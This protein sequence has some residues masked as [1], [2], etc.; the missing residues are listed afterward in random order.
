MP[1]VHQQRRD[2]IAGVALVV[3]SAVSYGTV[4]ILAK[5]T[6]R[7]GVTLPEFL[8][9]RFGVAAVLLWIVVAATRGALPRRDRVLALVL[10][11]A[12][13]YAGQSAAFFAALE[14]IPASTT[15]LLL[16]IYPAVV[17]LAAAALLHE[18]LTARK[19]WAIVIAFAGTSMLV[20]GQLSGAEPVGIA[21]ALL[22][23]VI[24]SAYVLAGSRLFADLPPLATAATVM[25]STAA[26][27]I[28]FALLAGRFA[29]PAGASQLGLIGAV[30]IV[31]TAIPVLAFVVG[32]PRIG[33]SRASI[34]STF[35]P[36]VTVLLATVVLAEP[37]RPLQLAGAA[38]IVASVVVLEAGRP[39]GQPA[40]I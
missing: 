16:Y 32:M 17:T 39:S 22:S 6:F 8:A 13:G 28:A 35:E 19:L 10:M 29:V 27:Y 24:Y 2:G 23:A 33:P 15:A 20:Q 9:W 18:Q 12:V 26:T 38:C 36:A 14:R 37:L 21:F 25:T 11:G 31:G 1:D 40:Q 7:T 4:P 34:L 5:L 30:A 3:V